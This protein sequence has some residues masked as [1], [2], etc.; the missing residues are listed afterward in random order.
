LELNYGGQRKIIENQ[1]FDEE[2]N[3]FNSMMKSFASGISSVKGS[4]LDVDKFVNFATGKNSPY[5]DLNVRTPVDKKKIF[6]NLKQT[7]SSLLRKAQ[8]MNKPVHSNRKLFSDKVSNVPQNKFELSNKENNCDN[9]VTKNSNNMAVSPMP[10]VKGTWGKFNSPGL[11]EKATIMGTPDTAFYKSPDVLN[12]HRQNL[13]NASQVATPLNGLKG[14]LVANSTWGSTQANFGNFR[15]SILL[16]T[17]EFKSRNNDLVEMGSS[18]QE[19]SAQKGTL[20]SI[21][22]KSRAQSPFESLHYS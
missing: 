6:G 16:S 15:G 22:L 7:S 9:T 14:S 21:G 17:I 8:A 18:N 10:S 2:G 20:K 12:P 13:N 11:T 3:I 1:F 19:H 4:P 5:W